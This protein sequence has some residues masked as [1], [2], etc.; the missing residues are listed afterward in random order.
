MKMRKLLPVITVITLASTAVSSADLTIHYNFVGGTVVQDGFG[1]LSEVKTLGGLSGLT[2]IDQVVARLNLTTG[3]VSDPMY[4]GDLYSSLTFGTS[5]ESQRIA[6]L[7][8]RPGR[9]NSDAFGSDLSSLNVTLDD[10]VAGTNVWA[11]TS[12]TGAY[13][14]DGRLS[15]NPNAPGVA[16]NPGVNS[17][18]ALNGTTFDS[19]RVSLLVADFSGGG[20]A[21]LA[22]WGVSVTGGAATTGTFTPGANASISD[23]GTG[24]TTVGAIL[25]T[26]GASGGSLEISVGGTLTFSNGVIGS[27]GVS[28][29]GA[30]TLVLEDS[31]SYTGPTSIS[32]GKLV[33]TDTLGS[34]AVT[35]SGSGAILATGTTATIGSTL[36]VNNGSILAVGDAANT[37]TATATVNGATTFNNDSI[38]SWDINDTG[39]S[40]DKLVTSGIAGEVISGDAIFRIVASDDLVSNSFWNSSKTWT[41]IFTT[42]GSAG[43]EN[44]AEIFGSSV[45]VVNSSFNSI[46]PVGGSFS[47]SGNTLIW[48]AV[49]EPSSVL[50]GFLITAG[51]L[52]R[53]RVA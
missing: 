7:L 3:D 1:Q 10:S 20:S 51:L 11:A 39:M 44:W 46:T 17:L 12:A 16:F 52:R 53:R 36:T 40:Y 31:N 43:I 26:S 29:T 38:F 34:S 30:G 41:D 50:A 5:E 28:K 45:S 15:V 47:V 22:G 13:N 48:T 37:S 19:N 42:N 25:D 18:T 49:P 24:D 2:E 21:T 8:N 9:D 6:V 23:S 32:E 4:L 27:G 14:S 33:V 35:V